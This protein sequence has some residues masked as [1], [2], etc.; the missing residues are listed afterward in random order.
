MYF[1]MHQSLE[2]NYFCQKNIKNKKIEIHVFPEGGLNP[3]PLILN[4][5]A[6]ITRSKNLTQDIDKTYRTK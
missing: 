3:S 1:I 6:F 5:T 2:Y 4:F